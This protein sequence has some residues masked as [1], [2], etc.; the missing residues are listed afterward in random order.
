[1]TFR[2]RDWPLAWLG[3]SPL[4]SRRSAHVGQ[5]VFGVSAPQEWFACV[6]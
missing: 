2:N 6:T 4:K 1:M 3:S 5:V